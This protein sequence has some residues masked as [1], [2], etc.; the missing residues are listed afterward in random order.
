MSLEL[1][2]KMTVPGPSLKSTHRILSID[3][4]TNHLGY[5]ISEVYLMDPYEP[6]EVIEVDTLQPGNLAKP[7]TTL[8]EV[9]GE[10]VAKLY[11]LEQAIKRILERFKPDIIVSESPYMG[12]FPQ[13]YAA[14]VEC[15]K[16]IRSALIDFDPC[17]P[18][19]SIDPAT[20][21]A[22][23]GVSGKSGDKNL[24]STAIKKL[25]DEKKLILP[26]N[27]SELDEHSIDAI[28]VGY[29]YLFPKVPVKKS[30]TKH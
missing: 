2:L 10:K 3:P 29:A 11:A 12:Q 27:L 15:L 6:M 17:K 4:G 24:M 25:I 16:S 20:I 7:F 23:V 9:H 30:R 26:C 28:A 22:S 21:K 18:L 13:A 5:A 1:S 19:N 8:I 14:L